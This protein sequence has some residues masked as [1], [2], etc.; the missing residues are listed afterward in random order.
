MTLMNTRSC[1]R[2]ST[3]G[4]QRPRDD[5]KLQVNINSVFSTMLSVGILVRK[6]TLSGTRSKLLCRGVLRN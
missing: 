6:E 2:H 1:I 3:V 4:R 5:I